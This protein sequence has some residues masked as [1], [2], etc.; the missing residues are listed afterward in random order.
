MKANKGATRLL[1]LVLAVGLILSTVSCTGTAYYGVSV[2]GPYYGYPYGGVYGGPVYGGGVI[3]GPRLDLVA[4]VRLLPAAA[5]AA[6]RGSA[7]AASATWPPLLA[8]ISSGASVASVAR[9]NLINSCRCAAS[10]LGP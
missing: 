6:A 2:G 7:L 8:A 4:S 5:A 9:A 3:V 10:H 1:L